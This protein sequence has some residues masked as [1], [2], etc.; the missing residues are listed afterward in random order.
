MFRNPAEPSRFFNDLA[1]GQGTALSIAQEKNSMKASK[2]LAVAT[3]VAGL[4][5]GG[6]A[7]IAQVDASRAERSAEKQTGPTPWR[8][9][10]T[11][12]G[13]PLAR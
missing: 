3:M 11:Q 1:L 8:D 5:S 2:I 9:F 13:A 6:A 12:A 4:C 7:G 10:R